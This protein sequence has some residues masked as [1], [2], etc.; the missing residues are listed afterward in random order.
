METH[1][2]LATIADGKAAAS[3]NCKTALGRREQKLQKLNWMGPDWVGPGVFRWDAVE[4]RG[5]HRIFVS[6]LCFRVLD[7]I[8]PQSRGWAS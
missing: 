1:M 3:D 5:L 4:N 7:T 8:A 2:F 6:R